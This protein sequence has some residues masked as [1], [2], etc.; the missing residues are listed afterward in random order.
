LQVLLVRNPL[1]HRY[2]RVELALGG[3][4]ELAIRL[5]APTTLLDGNDLMLPTEESFEPAIEVLIKQ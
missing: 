5:A 2:Q 3:L 1:V 4:D